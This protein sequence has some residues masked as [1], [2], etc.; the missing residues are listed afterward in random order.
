MSIALAA[1]LAYIALSTGDA[2]AP[3]CGKRCGARAFG[4]RVSCV[5]R[6]AGPLPTEDFKTCAVWQPHARS[7]RLRR[8]SVK[9]NWASE[10]GFAGVP[11]ATFGVGDSR[12]RPLGAASQSG[13]LWHECGERVSALEPWGRLRGTRVRTTVPGQMISVP[14]LRLAWWRSCGGEANPPTVWSATRWLRARR[15]RRRGRPP[16]AVGER[17]RALAA[18]D[19]GVTS[20][21]RVEHRGNVGPRSASSGDDQRFRRRP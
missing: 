8:R 4:V 13:G 7:V 18:T 2:M 5:H 12:P 6:A 15:L 1:T 21:I 11:V 14:G 9:P 10:T 3:Q 20:V 17:A 16:V 19:R